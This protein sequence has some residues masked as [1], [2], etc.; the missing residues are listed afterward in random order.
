[1]LATGTLLL[2]DNIIDQATATHGRQCRR[3]CF[4]EPV[5]SSRPVACQRHDGACL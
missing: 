2:V 4:H 5:G 3:F 1:M